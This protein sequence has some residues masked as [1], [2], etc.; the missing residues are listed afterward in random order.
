M[1]H[2]VRSIRRSQLKQT[3]G[4]QRDDG[5]MA[6]ARFLVRHRRGRS[7][8]YIQWRDGKRIREKYWGVVV[9]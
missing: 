6:Q 7:Y 3:I 2:Y 1:K 4:M 5:S 8:A 9:D